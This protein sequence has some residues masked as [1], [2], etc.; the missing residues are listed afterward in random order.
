MKDFVKAL[1][2]HAKV[3]F[4]KG[5]RDE[6][7]PDLNEPDEDTTYWVCTQGG[8]D[9]LERNESR[10]SRFYFHCACLCFFQDAPALCQARLYW[11]RAP[12]TCNTGAYANNQCCGRICASSGRYVKSCSA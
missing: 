2:K 1:E 12:L 11:K 10:S 8:A 6:V 5:E 9:L 7:N 4:P 3:R